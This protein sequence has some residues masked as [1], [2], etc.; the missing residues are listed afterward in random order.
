MGYIDLTISDE[1]L[2]LEVNQDYFVEWVNGYIEIA[3]L[4]GTAFNS[5]NRDQ[6]I[7]YGPNKRGSQYRHRYYVI[8]ADRIKSR[9]PSTRILHPKV[10]FLLGI[11][12]G[13]ASI[14]LPVIFLMS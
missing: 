12:I 1:T 3:K 14:A 6:F 5:D 4:K 7:F 8:D 13:A 2:I 11:A 10:W 9:A